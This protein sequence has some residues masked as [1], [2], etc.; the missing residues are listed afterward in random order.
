M[1]WEIFQE[2]IQTLLSY[3]GSVVAKGIGIIL[4]T[5]F[6]IF[7]AAVIRHIN[8]FMAFLLASLLVIWTELSLRSNRY[9]AR[10]T[11]DLTKA[12]GQAKTGDLVLFRRFQS[13]DLPE[14]FFYRWIN[15]WW[16]RPYFGHIGILVRDSQNIFILHSEHESRFD[17]LTQTHKHGVIL[18]PALPLIQDYPGRVHIVPSNLSDKL[19]PGRLLRDARTLSH[20]P[21]LMISCSNLLQQLLYNQGLFRVPPSLIFQTRLNRFLEPEM[22][23]QTINFN[24]PLLLENQ[25]L[26]NNSYPV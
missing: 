23:T 26:K 6:A 7:F 20:L 9:F 10:E 4:I 16:S 13:H 21:F 17:H 14:A 12:L 11:Q 3:Q 25:Y 2:D 19:D 18:S 22:Y 24:E 15:S 1:T 8:V 5:I